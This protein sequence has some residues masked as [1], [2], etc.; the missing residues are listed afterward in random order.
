MVKESSDQ[1][2]LFQIHCEV[3]FRGIYWGVFGLLAALHTTPKHS[4]LEQ[5]LKVKLSQFCGWIG[6]SWVVLS[7]DLRIAAI[8]LESSKD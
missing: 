4:D 1:N 8:V 5:T 3:G 7:S 6:L 2:A